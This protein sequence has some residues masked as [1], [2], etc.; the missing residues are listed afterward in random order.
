M[1]SPFPRPSHCLTP[2]LWACHSV[3]LKETWEGYGG[4]GTFSGWIWEVEDERRQFPGRERAG[5]EGAEVS[6]RRSRSCSLSSVHVPCHCWGLCVA[7][8]DAHIG[9][10]HLCQAWGSLTQ[11]GGQEC[12]QGAPTSS[13]RPPSPPRAFLA[14][15][16]SQV[17]RL[18]LLRFCCG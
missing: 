10:G 11:A 7:S 4:T 14:F 5:G 8:R 17:S 6:A 18:P 12:S 9:R 2:H 13:C 3:E 16:I 1:G 15:L